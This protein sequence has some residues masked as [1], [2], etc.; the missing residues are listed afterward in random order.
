MNTMEVSAAERQAYE[1]IRNWLSSRCGISYPEHKSPVL[2]QRLARVTRGF[3]YT[4]LNELAQGILNEKIEEVQLAVMHAASTNHTY[5]FREP[6][7]LRNFQD[8]ILNDLRNRREVRIWSAAASTGDEAYSIAILFAE[9]LGIEALGR[10]NILGT[11][12]SGPVVER[13]EM[14]VFPKRQFAQTDP[15]LLRRYFEPTGIEQFRV[16]EKIRRTC[17]FRR[18]NLMAQPYPFSKP[19][20][21]VFCRNILYYF[22]KADQTKTLEA[23][24]DVTEPGGWLVT[25]VTESIRDLGS[26][27]EPVTTGIYRRA[28]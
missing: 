8:M 15:D 24:Y 23:I 26:R 4:N 3:G 22:E 5:F 6:E 16:I 18:M 28:K 11:D 21:V 14:G 27:W 13:A 19:F 9:T 10:L 20:Q 1:L 25:S 12:I 2:R 7:V 17:T